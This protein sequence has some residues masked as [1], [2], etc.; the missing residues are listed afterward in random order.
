MKNIKLT[1]AYDGTNYHGWQIQPD[2]TT[3]QE[4]IKNTLT[5]ILQENINLIGASRTDAKVHAK[6]QV[7]NFFTEKK[8]TS[9]DILLKLNKLLPQDIRI[10]KSEIVTDNFHARKS[11]VCKTYEY[12]IY[13]AKI[14]SPFHRNFSWFIEKNLNIELLNNISSDLIGK[15]NFLSFTGQKSSVKTH[16]RTVYEAFWKKKGDFFIFTISANGFLKN[17]I[18][19]TVGAIIAVNNGKE[20]KHF[21]KYLLA[22]K[23]RKEGKYCAPPQGL[24]LSQIKYNTV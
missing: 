12:F 21:L 17:M 19:K 4:V 20:N 1:I 10:L 5:L 18:R 6:C 9:C 24:Y 8:I 11:A 23:D 15:R 7:A 14:S 2:K 16:T 22:V 3:V 13:N